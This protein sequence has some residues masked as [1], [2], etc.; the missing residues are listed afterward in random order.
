[1][2]NT[3]IKGMVIFIA[4]VLVTSLLLTLPLILSS[5]GNKAIIDPGNYNYTHIHVTDYVEGHC[6]EIDKWWDNAT[7]IEVRLTE[8]KNGM[9]F[10]GGTYQLFESQNMC[11]YCND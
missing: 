10:S 7:G 3:L 6:F 9:F 5:C 4:M 2:R 8:S 11:P 1:M